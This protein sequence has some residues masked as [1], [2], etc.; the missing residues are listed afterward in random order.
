M[1]DV[2]AE[3]QALVA[4][5]GAERAAKTL[6]AWRAADVIEA[7]DGL[8]AEAAV[9]ILEHLSDEAAAGVFNTPG[10][11]KPS[12]LLEKLPEE[13]AARIFNE[14]HP[15][16]RAE[17]FRAL[18]K[19]A[20]DRLFDRLEEAAKTSLRRILAY[21]PDKAGGIMTTDFVAVPAGWTV[22]QVLD[23]IRTSGIGKSYAVYVIDEQS[24][25]LV[26]AVSLRELLIAEPLANIR[27]TSPQREPI[28]ASPDT[29]REDVARL[30]S[31]YDLLAEPITG[32]AG[33]LLGIVTV[34]DVIDAIV[35]E[36]TEDVQKFGGMEAIDGPYMRVG[37]LTTIK[38]RAGWLAALF[39]KRDADRKRDAAFFGRTP[40]S[41]RADAVHPAHHELGG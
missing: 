15:D 27:S 24:Q 36:T 2:R 9:K 14:V 34:D 12:S 4:Q 20:Q 41:G 31:K 40:K 13:R 38:K 22:K 25:R 33:N 16:R 5:S 23:R 30:I 32:E 21:P 26:Q 28:T 37:F 19:E 3:V 17:I 6:S 11:D 39:L 7:L 1:E 10:L 29:D 35:A 8:P 18:P